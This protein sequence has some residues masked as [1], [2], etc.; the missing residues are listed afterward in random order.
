MTDAANVEV[1]ST[2]LRPTIAAPGG[3]FIP[4]TK[5]TSVK[6][7]ARSSSPARYWGARQ[8]PDALVRRTVVVS[9]GPSSASVG[10]LPSRRAVPATDVATKS[11]R[12]CIM[13]IADLLVARRS[14]L[15]LAFQ[16]VQEAPV[17]SVSDDLLRARLDQARVLHAQCVE[18]QRVFCV[19]IP[20]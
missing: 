7:S 1:K 15:Q 6:P 2:S 12:L 4:G 3:P 14:H 8:M 20:P 19:E 10:T 13:A 11:R 17:G 9:G 5:R 16:L 18:P